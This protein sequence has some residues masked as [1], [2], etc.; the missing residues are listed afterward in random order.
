MC[1]IFK[2]LIQVRLQIHKY[3]TL[4]TQIIWLISDYLIISHHLMLVIN[5]SYINNNLGKN[6]KIWILNHNNCNNNLYNKTNK[7][8][9]FNY[10]VQILKEKL[11]VLL[12]K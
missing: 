5:N 2:I 3:K 9:K 10:L 4:K 8:I 12:N 6:N 1:W 11:K 7:K